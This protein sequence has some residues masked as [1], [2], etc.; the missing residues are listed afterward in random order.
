[1]QSELCEIKFASAG[2]IRYCHAQFSILIHFV[3]TEPEMYHMIIIK[4]VQNCKII[5]G[6]KIERVYN[7]SVCLETL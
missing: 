2:L 4:F 5:V 1:M 3:F 6:E 7:F